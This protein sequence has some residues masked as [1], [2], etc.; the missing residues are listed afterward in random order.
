VWH[1]SPTADIFI[2]MSQPFINYLKRKRAVS[3]INLEQ[4]LKICEGLILALCEIR[5]ENLP[6]PCGKRRKKFSIFTL[7]VYFLDI[8]KL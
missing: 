1:F 5:T 7:T 4:K 2:H 8:E 3:Q 6:K